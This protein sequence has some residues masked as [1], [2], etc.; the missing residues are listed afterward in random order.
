M[1]VMIRLMSIEIKSFSITRLKRYDGRAY[2]S[3]WKYIEIKSFSITRLKLKL[4]HL[5]QRG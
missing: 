2:N 1:V 4:G 3:A 5:P